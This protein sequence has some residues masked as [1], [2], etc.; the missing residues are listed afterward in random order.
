MALISLAIKTESPGSPIYR[1]TRIGRNG[2][3]FEIFKFRTMYEDSDERLTGFLRQNEHAR[4]EWKRFLKLRNDP[5]VTR[6]GGFLRRTSLDEL[7]QL[8]NVFLGQMS[9]VGPRPYL[10]EE[11]KSLPKEKLVFLRVLPGITGL[12]QVT[13]RSDTAF[14]YRLAI[15]AWYVRNW[16]LWLDIVI[17]LKTIKVVAMREGAY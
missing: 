5:R 6:I 1:Q 4:R 2:R 14:K 9:L 16:T 17:L 12:W 11:V 8:I 3:P 7:P 15:D 13:G 10:P